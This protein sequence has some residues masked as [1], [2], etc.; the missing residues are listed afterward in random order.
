MRRDEVIER[1][2]EHEG[3][4]RALGVGALYLFGSHARDEAGPG[5]DVDVYIERDPQRIR[6]LLDLMKVGRRLEELLN[7]KV[8]LGTRAGLHPL[9]RAT[10]EHEAIQVL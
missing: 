7:T 1:L 6:S 2:R 9:L 8:D 3:E 5:S 10:I 4:I